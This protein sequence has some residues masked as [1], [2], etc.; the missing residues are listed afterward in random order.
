LGQLVRQKSNV[1]RKVDISFLYGGTRI[2]RTEERSDE[3][4]GVACFCMLCT[5]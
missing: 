4:E 3:G 5:E 2:I 1:H